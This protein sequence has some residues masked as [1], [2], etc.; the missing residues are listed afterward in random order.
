[1]TSPWSVLPRLVFIH[2]SGEHATKIGAGTYQQQDYR[3]QALKVEKG[4]L[5][6]K[7]RPLHVRQSGMQLTEEYCMRTAQIKD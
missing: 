5:R 2:H 1:M 6:K 4:R 7:S 3:Q